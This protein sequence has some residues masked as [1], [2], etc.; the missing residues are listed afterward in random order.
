MPYIGA[1]NNSTTYLASNTEPFTRC[2]CPICNMTS[3][4]EE[5]FDPDVIPDIEDSYE[6]RAV[7]DADRIIDAAILAMEKPR[8]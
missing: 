7:Q 2:R 6:Y 5:S 1:V 3:E 8:R 4:I